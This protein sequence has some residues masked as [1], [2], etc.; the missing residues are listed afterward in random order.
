MTQAKV[1]VVGAGIGGLYAVWRL[2]EQGF[3]VIALEKAGD[4]GGVWYYNGYPGARVDIQSLEYSY[5]FSPELY[6]DWKWSERYASQPELLAYLRHVADRFDLRGH[7]RFNTRM[8]G[9]DWDA[10]RAVWTVQTDSGTTIECN[11][12][13]MATGALSEPKKPDF[14][15]LDSFEGVWAQTADWP[16][17]PVAL[18]GK[19][20]GLIGTGSSGIQ[21]APELAGLARHLT[22]FQRSPNFSI[23][24]RNRPLDDALWDQLRA[25]VTGNR[26]WLMEQSRGG[27]YPV[28]GLVP[29][30]ARDCTPAEQQ[31]MLERQWA[32]GSQHIK[33]VFT[34]QNVDMQANAI[35]ADFVRGKIR[36]RVQDPALAD[37][38]C[39]TDHPI[40]SRRIAM[41]SGYYETFNRENVT[42]VNLR[43]NPIRCITPRGVLTDQGEIE[44]DVIIFA[45]GFHAF[46]GALDSA[47]IRNHLGRSPTATWGAGPRTA[48]GIMAP[49]CPNLFLPTGAGSPSVLSNLV[50]LNELSMDWIAGVIAHME[51]YGLAALQPKAQTIEAWTAHV[52][53][54]AD[55]QLRRQVQNY[56]VHVN[57][58]GS[59]VFV[60]YVG[61]MDRYKA[62]LDKELAAGLPGFDLTPAI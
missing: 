62:A 32:Y 33:F 18:E 15:G 24:A 50:I 27:Q 4:V 39:P 13:I 12:I 22:V 28:P 6:N 36:E 11:F 46:N 35:V 59:R 52:A 43:D 5:H 57:P 47:G 42:L 60:P 2:R 23:P 31:E 55:V 38:L 19:R 54:V 9:A 14:P 30:P 37:V 41:D 20:I 3:S 58:D 10:G 61:G 1:V 49:D 48:Y 16:R 8:T 45:I 26:R 56:M 51:R 7:F 44:L 21:A 34:D 40:G 53:E 29:R 25:D 17:Q